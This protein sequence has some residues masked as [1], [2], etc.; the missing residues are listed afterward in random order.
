MRMDR[1]AG[2]LYSPAPE[3]YFITFSSAASFTLGFGEQQ[4]FSSPPTFYY[5]TDKITWNQ[6]DFTDINASNGVLYLYGVG[7]QRASL[8]DT[9]TFNIKNTSTA[10][11][12]DGN[13]EFL[14][15]KDTVLA[16]QHPEMDSFCYYYL[17]RG[18]SQLSSCPKLPATQLTESCYE[19]M[20]Y[21]CSLLTSIPE[22]PATILPNYC[23]KNMF[24][25]CA[26][27]NII[28]DPDPYSPP[29]VGY[30]RYK[31]PLTGTIT[32]I[33]TDSTYQMFNDFDYSSV[34]PM[35]Y[36]TNA[37]IVLAN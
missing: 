36:Y 30:N 14:L 20:F 7:N 12:C 11:R 28:P 19:G 22:L 15:D 31:F 25:Y 29:P 10:V 8:L 26:S 23:Y 32:S 6:V 4:G 27:I 5:S 34:L 37:T 21:G 1:R 35:T 16:G 18:N 9:K 2:L 24:N 17:F 3:D 13:I 33:G